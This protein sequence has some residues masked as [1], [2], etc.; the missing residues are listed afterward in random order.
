MR[1]VGVALA[2]AFVALRVVMIA[3]VLAAAGY[4]LVA[5]KPIGGGGGGALTSLVP[6]NSKAQSAERTS[7]TQFAFPIITR[8]LIVVRDPRGLPTAQ[9][10]GIVRLG[11]QLTHQQLPRYRAIAGALPLINML[12][13]RPLMR[14]HGTTALLYLYF[15]P[16]VSE[17]RQTRIA[18]ELARERIG[19]QPGEAVDVTGEVPASARQG[20]LIEDGLEWVQLATILLVAL[21]V[22]LRFRALGAAAITIVAVLC[23]Y[24]IAERVVG[25]AGRA[26][27]IAT[28]AQV[29]P[30][31]VVLV[32]GVTTDYSIFFIS[33]F[34][35]LVGEGV[36]RRKAAVRVVRAITPIVFTA[37]LTVAAGTG[38][39]T[40]ARLEFLRSFGPGLAIA[41]AIAMLVAIVLVPAALALGGPRVFW[42]SRLA[43]QTPERSAPD[44]HA[45]RDLGLP[46]HSNPEA[47]PAGSEPQPQPSGRGGQTAA[48]GER[49]PRRLSPARLAARHPIVGIVLAVLVVGGAASGLGKLALGDEIITGLPS[50]SEARR[51]YEQLSRGFSPGFI[52]PAVAVVRGTK[53]AAQH[54]ALARLQRKL[55]EQPGVAGVIGPRASA[56]QQAV[57]LGPPGSI[58]TAPAPQLA[59]A[60]ARAREA[61]TV[62]PYAS[63]VRYPL[64]FAGDPLGPHA[65]VHARELQSSLPALLA[66][67]GLGFARGQLAGDT[68][69]ST[70]VVDA[71]LKDLARV[72]PVMLAAIFIVV[73]IYLRALVAP[74]YLILTSLMAVLGALGLTVYVLQELAGYGSLAYY[75]LFTAAVLL[76][77]LGSD[78]NVFMVGRI[79]QEG[80]RRELSEAVEVAAARAARPIST[81]GLVLALAFALLAI[82][83]VRA[84]R[85]IAFTMALGLLI[86]A[87]IVRTILVPALLSLVG[88]RSAWPGK[89]LAETE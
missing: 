42:P 60:L 22:G 38:A 54:Q 63:A 25:V 40:V 45:Q 82:V 19:R 46:Q 21:A 5:L 20:T 67:S 47:A 81:A 50:G 57:R 64:I 36:D 24:V 14:E 23:A 13:S 62:S 79:W 59:G 89:A 73:A 75:L 72:G 17:Y 85:E 49:E 70:E 27:G 1:A 52:A 68:A 18:R 83:Q 33:R 39:L 34:R 12:G 58:S 10:I 43:S 53:V 80:R 65:I 66:S 56:L 3:I 2:R 69:L 30:V 84:F 48:S 77:S 37:G 4:S 44:P 29:G 15:R 55:E 41:V 7:A 87:F 32:F 74:A 28:P 51:G 9:A 86:D 11:G 8:T 78:Y 26:S 35:T 61:L 16:S 76:V 88:P 6:N 71:T 31:L